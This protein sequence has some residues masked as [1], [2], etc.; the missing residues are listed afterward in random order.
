MSDASNERTTPSARRRR[1]TLGGVLWVETLD[2]P[3]HVS[4]WLE[5][6]V[7]MSLSADDGP[8]DLTI[9]FARSLGATPYQRLDVNGNTFGFDARNFFL[10][11]RSGARA[12]LNF[13]QLAPGA[14]LTCE[15]A[16][17]FDEPL[18]RSI[19]AVLALAKGW[20]LLH[21]SAFEYCDV[22]VLVTGWQ[23]SGKSE[24]LLGMRGEGRFISDEPTLVHAAT[25][26][27]IPSGA[28]LPLWDWQVAQLGCEDDLEPA[29]RRR[30][31]MVRALRRML[32]SLSGD[33][34]PA[35]G[36]A[37]VRRRLKAITR[38][39]IPPQ[40][41]FQ[42]VGE[43][44]RVTVGVVI[45]GSIGLT[46]IRSMSGETLAKKMVISQTAE[47]GALMERYN[48]FLH[49]FPE[50]R[51]E[52]L[53]GAAERELSLLT[54]LFRD[55]I[56]LDIVHPYPGTLSQHGALARQAIRAALTPAAANANV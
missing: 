34:I 6:E 26:R 9:R 40:R 29:H 47:R 52:M 20:L 38:L 41:L 17:R 23:S 25:G 37:S 44:E 55:R 8:S 50:R 48:Q 5:S 36:V 24:F 39:P 15:Y 49:V 22:G 51:S 32:P 33:G 13:E 21:G 43:H 27:L 16:W 56:V 10:V 53:D 45:T 12:R 28:L 11:D 54:E 30:I 4:R 3:E 14:E 2:E 31:R 42:I 35:R 19:L 1:Y 46:A 7:G 18:L